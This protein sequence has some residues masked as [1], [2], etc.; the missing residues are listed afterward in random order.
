M[1]FFLFSSLLFPWKR[2]RWSRIKRHLSLSLLLETKI[3]DNRGPR[4]REE[5]DTLETTKVG[6]LML[7]G[8]NEAGYYTLSQNVYNSLFKYEA[9]KIRIYRWENFLES[10]ESSKKDY[11]ISE[12]RNLSANLWRKCYR[13]MFHERKTLEFDD[14][15][16][17]QIVFQ[18]IL[19]IPRNPLWNRSVLSFLLNGII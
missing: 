14:E 6:W 9:W 10:D 12:E 8:Y 4:E 2:N 1:G 16:I 7:T 13:R 18:S 3:G 11:P 5:K 15:V 17:V 19:W